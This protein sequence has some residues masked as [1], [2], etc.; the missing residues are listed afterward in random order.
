[1]AGQPIPITVIEDANF[2]QWL[3]KVPEFERNWLTETDSLHTNNSY[4]LI[5]DVSGK[6][7]RVVVRVVN[8]QDLSYIGALPLSLPAQHAYRLTELP[9]KESYEQ[10]SLM[11]LLGAYQFN[12]YKKP[13]RSAAELVFEADIDKKKVLAVQSGIYLA[14]DL[15][16][17]PPNDMGPAEIA[18][19]CAKI[20]SDYDAQFFQI[21]GENL[22]IERFPA[23]YAVGKGSSRAPRLLELQAGAQH[24][25]KLVIVGKGVAFD[26]GGLNLKPAADMALM[27]KD[28]G[29]AA[30]A[31]G[32]AQAILALQLPIHLRVLI[33]AVE[34]SVS[35][36]AYRPSDVIETRLGKRVEID[37]TDAEG[38]VILADA[39]AYGLEDKPDL[40]IDLATLTGA[41]RVAL[42]T[43]VPIYFTNQ[44]H[45]HEKL[46]SA[47]NTHNE[48][49]W[50]LPLYAAYRSFLDSK[51]ADIMNSG[52]SRYAGAITAALFLQEFVSPSAPWV[53]IDFMGWNLHASPGKPIGGDAM[54]LRAVLE[55]V[56]G[57]VSG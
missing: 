9:A 37:N 45:L 15:I 13:S 3:H 33:P 24:A 53:H 14:R 23:I 12:R 34:N 29:G 4:A 20:A 43:D 48:M 1:M 50:R 10:A 8:R 40:I 46:S 5:P 19:A 22:L 38:R 30:V 35:G 18:E 25:F 2:T 32:L 7:S 52:S 11:W 57:M 36:E 39:L 6:L 42:G 51:V 16:N 44:D 28:M 17:T 47:A 27:K 49:M 31:L 56:S 21:V 26:T 55:F 54:C 41:A